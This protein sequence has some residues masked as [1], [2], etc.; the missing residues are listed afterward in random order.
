MRG[1]FFMYSRLATRGILPVSETSVA[2]S[3]HAA[4]GGIAEVLL[5]GLRTMRKAFSAKIIISLF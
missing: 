3:K 1:C 5:T 2:I 4:K